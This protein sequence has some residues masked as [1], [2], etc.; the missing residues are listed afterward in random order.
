MKIRRI[1]FVCLISLSLSHGLRAQNGNPTAGSTPT[2]DLSIYQDRPR[3]RALRLA[4]GETLEIDG[5]LDEA[6]WGRAVPAMNFIQQDP[7][8]GQPATERTEVRFLLSGDTLYMGVV[9][10]DSEPEGVIA[11]TMQRDAALSAD[12]RF[13]WTFDTYLDARSAYYFEM[14]PNGSLGD[15]LIRSSNA[16][17][18]SDTGRAWDG[19]WNGEVQVS[20]IGWTLEIEI[21]FRTLNFNPNAP[22]WGVNF[23]RTIRRKEEESSLDRMGA[24]P[25]LEST[26][27][28]RA[29]R[30]NFRCQSGCGTRRAALCVRKI[31]RCSRTQPR[32][33][34]RGRW[35]CRFHLRH[36][37]PRSE[38]SSP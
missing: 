35:W 31:R 37:T 30:R 7:D 22:A 36:Y 6:V 19:I 34:I 1:I 21:P 9:C 38:D 20:E 3:V 28:F 26:G 2:D 14:N 13:M 15:A 16:T 10:Y 4:E 11:N 33:R 29:A 8:Q 27:E 17:N 12:D 23:Q 5:R 25:G 18:T 24:Q 32:I